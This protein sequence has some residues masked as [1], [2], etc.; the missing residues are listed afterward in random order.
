MA[1]LADKLVFPAPEPSYTKDSF[2]NHL[3][4]IP[5]NRALSP[6]RVDQEQ[7]AEGIPCM[8]LPAERAAG[9]ILFFHGNAEDLGLSHAFVQ[10]M[11]DQFKMNVLSVEYPGYGLLKW[12]SASETVLKEVVLTVFRFVVDELRVAYEQIYLFGRSIGSGPA[13][14]LAST[15]PVGGLILVAAFASINE[16]IKS[17]A[18]SLVARAFT[19]RFPNIQ[20][21]SNVSCPTLFIHGEKDNLVPPEQSVALFKQCRARKLLI[22]PPALEHNT[23]LWSDASFLAVPAINFFGLPGYQQDSPVTMPHHVFED[24]RQ[25]FLLRK[26]SKRRPHSTG[27]ISGRQEN[28]SQNTSNP[29]FL[30]CGC[31][32]NKVRAKPSGAQTI[33]QEP[34]PFDSREHEWTPE[35]GPNSLTLLEARSR[36]RA[37]SPHSHSAGELPAAA[38]NAKAGLL[39]ERLHARARGKLAATKV[40][41]V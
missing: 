13:T 19:E 3:C 12:M 41:E 23:N 6:E 1:T 40:Q 20:L 38:A 11:R 4:W 32:T 25:K 33:Q 9:V 22:T 14:Y 35:L 39:S 18:G 7:Y 31:P 34:P 37:V 29:W 10:H 27:A 15:F 36:S 21:I 26:Q 17:L 30:F 16:V 5:W 8:W 2:K 28:T 24:G